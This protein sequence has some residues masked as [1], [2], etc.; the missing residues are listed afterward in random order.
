M[1]A[2][3]YTIPAGQPFLRTLAQA[4]LDG[5]LPRLDGQKPD[6][7]SLPGLTLMLP[8][9]RAARAAEDAFLAVSGASA[10]L[11]PR[12]KPIADG[13]EDGSFF[14]GKADASSGD[15][16]LDIP[17]AI[18]AL[19][20]Q[21]ILT[22]L[23][24]RWRQASEQNSAAPDTEIRNTPAQAAR[25]AQSLAD[26]MD[27]VER[28][29]VPLTNIAGLVPDGFAEH[30]ETTVQF[31]KIVT[32]VWPAILAGRGVLSPMSRRNAV[33]EAY[34]RQIANDSAA[35]P[36]II[37]GITGSIPSTVTLMRAVLDKADGAI[38]LPNLDLSLDAESW[39]AIVPNHPEHPQ[40]GLK[41]LLD[42]LGVDR[43]DVKTLV[44]AES[45][46]AAREAFFSEA[47]RPSATTGHWHTYAATADAA[48]V[49][50]TLAGI[51]L[52]EAASAHE[53]A[54]TIALI[55]REAVEVPG[56][57]AALV[58]PD[59]VLAR[60]VAIRL[61]SWGIRVDDSAGRPFA[62]TVPGTFL[63][64]V[65]DA[66]MRGFA[67]AQTMALLKHPLCRIGLKAFDIRR[68][69]RALELAAFRNREAYLGQDL[70]G[71]AHAL[72]V[73]E[74]AS[75]EG[76][77]GSRA[78]Q[79]LWDEDRAGARDLALRLT[80]V[81]QPLTSLYD[82]PKAKPLAD[83]AKAHAACAEALAAL[84][85]EEAS[86]NPLWQ[87]EAGT[88]ARGFFEELLRSDSSTDVLI[89]PSGYADMY[90]AL[91]ASANVRERN[92]V[93]PRVTIWGASEARL[94]QAGITIIGS[95]NEGTW[96]K[97]A[98][99]GAWLNRPMRSDMKLP[100][101]EA[102][103]G[104]LAH[105][106]QCLLG[107]PRVILTRSQKSGNAPSVPSRWLMRI[108][109]LLDG[110]GARDGLNPD[111][112]W[113]A[114]ARARDHI[115]E[116]NRIR[117]APPRPSPPLSVRP[118]KL[119]VTRIEPWIKNPYAIFARDILKLEPLPELGARPGQ[120]LRGSL[121]HG[122]MAAF[123]KKFPGE[124]PAG[125]RQEL[126]G[127]ARDV[128]A[129][130]AAHPRI[131]AFWLPRLSRF[132][133][134][135]AETEPER[136]KQSRA[137]YAETSGVLSFDAPNGL[138]TISARA[139]RIDASSDG[140]VITDYKTGQIPSS[141]AVASGAKPQLPLE[142]AIALG[143]SGFPNVGGEAVSGLRF[144]GASGGE[145]PGDETWVKPKDH[146]TP[147]ELAAQALA[148][149][150]RLVASYD[151]PAMPY[152]A[153]RRQG[154]DYEYDDFALLARVAE[155]PVAIETGDTSQ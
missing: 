56:Q 154:Y 99:P 21:L 127:V 45:A 102:E 33:I 31:L 11:L 75:L 53:E 80:Q 42:R 153:V 4:I 120:N 147:A 131:A 146:G 104:R 86:E 58:S 17:P 118:R 90:K 144:I 67:P 79:R 20:R 125:I 140:L 60:R 27:E 128:L 83:Y 92:A 108:S 71:I 95:L 48:A 76:H 74:S 29:N 113:L 114:W 59:R 69:A 38:V 47:L 22:Q 105:D 135:F 3:L 85:P 109:A 88:E 98:E 9:R 136:R 50:K 129:L 30:W 49:K 78:A 94:Q 70:A 36:V 133:D 117:I 72:D 150:Q 73:F 57:T 14:A 141:N 39:N 139:D 7:L 2:R 16:A 134:W 41:I 64:L 110:M 8:T 6:A 10:L 142:A 65:I 51:S 40:Y 61:Q 13:D 19:E 145:P 24:L 124:L 54:E 116:A 63:S 155:W 26:L 96:P 23:I 81:C 32:D 152:A 89:K 77:Y 5:R 28:E 66:V 112:P 82:D 55:L 97:A 87:G 25:L 132:L 34:A 15:F 103:I 149:L 106:F 101:P 68:F 37:A 121:V 52:I 111:R 1:T 123:V 100:P 138:F 93:H 137:V 130:Y 126:D 62:K 143:A 122:V 91:R 107:G 46:S 115:D 35:D 44:V 84:P 151:D 119:S 12:I 18:S 43:S 148:G